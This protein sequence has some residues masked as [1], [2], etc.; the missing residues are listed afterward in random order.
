MAAP[1]T[2]IDTNAYVAL[3]SG[4]A[5]IA[6]ILHDSSAVLLSPIVLG[7]LQEGFANGSRQSA[8]LETLAEFR[9]KPRA[10]AVPITD[11]TAEWYASLKQA[12]RRA[13]TPIPIHDIWIAASCMEHGAKLLSLDA[14]FDVVQGLLRWLL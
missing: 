9:A 11:T 3:L 1:R 12:L 7:E 5:R 8:N 13:G 6:N 2:L 10:V 14:H 4:D